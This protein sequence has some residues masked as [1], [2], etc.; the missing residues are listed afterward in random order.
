M[1]AGMVRYADYRTET[2]GEENAF[3]PVMTKF[4]SF[5]HEREFRV[6]V[7]IHEGAELVETDADLSSAGVH[8]PFILDTRIESIWVAPKA[9]EW[10]AATVSGLVQDVG[11]QGVTV[12]HS[13]L[14]EQPF[15]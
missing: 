7:S 6:V 2:I 9:S 15:F 10:F 1:F 8:I 13:H 4:R 5:A 11:L 3:V 12:N 14:D